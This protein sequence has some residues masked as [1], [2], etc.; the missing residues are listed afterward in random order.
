LKNL[1][2]EKIICDC[3]KYRDEIDITVMIDAVNANS[4]DKSLMRFAEYT[5]TLG[6]GEDIR[7]YM[8]VLRE[9]D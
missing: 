8:E 5:K 9:N 3:I 6:V 4:T 7:K 2:K 1:N